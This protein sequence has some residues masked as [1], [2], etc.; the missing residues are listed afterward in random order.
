[1]LIKLN[2]A[3]VYV[4]HDA[5]G[6]VAARKFAIEDALQ[7][8]TI[9]D[10]YASGDLVRFVHALPGDHILGILAAGQNVQ[11][12]TRLVSDGAGSLIAGDTDSDAV[13]TALEDRDASATDQ[14]LEARRIR[15]EVI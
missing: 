3:G 15:I 12:G 9:D 1:M 14:S 4:P 6:V 10:A 5:S 8:N 13:A 7:G 11:D 2:N